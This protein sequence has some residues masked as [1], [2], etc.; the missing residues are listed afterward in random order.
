MSVSDLLSDREREILCLVATGASNKEIAQQL[1]ISTNTVKV[2]LR[3]IFDK[4][5][6]TSRT[7]AAMVAVAE[8]M[9]AGFPKAD[10]SRESTLGSLAVPLETD[11]HLDIVGESVIKRGITRWQ[12]SIVILGLVIIG[13]GIIIIWRLSQKPTAELPGASSAA[14]KVL[15]P[16]QHARS[17]LAAAVI[18]NQIYA[19]AGRS[20]EG[21]TGVVE[22]YDPNS[23]SW[24]AREDKPVA[25][26]E[27]QGVVIGGKIYVP[28]GQLA[29][30][31]YTD[32]LEIYDP[33]RDEWSRGE[34]LPMQGSSY[35]LV[36][37]EGKMYL[38][39]GMN[40]GGVLDTILVYD[41]DS[42][43][44]AYKSSLPI[45]RAYPGVVEVGGAIYLLGG[46]DGRRALD[47]VEIYRPNL[48]D[49]DGSPWTTLDEM[50]DKRYGMGITSLLEVIYLLGGSESQENGM[51]MRGYLTRT[52]EW[53]T[54][55]KPDGDSWTG[56]GLVSVGNSIYAFGGK[57]G[58]TPIADLQSMQVVYISVL[59]YIP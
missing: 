14:W 53:L 31:E 39:G 43:H 4:I 48:D 44:W 54:I 16:M 23:N 42:N 19:L 7:E 25:V 20:V 56:M 8:G 49:G 33:I 1:F 50:P 21:V 13:I 29:S 17:G 18:N 27:V 6:V 38:F 22:C 10:D 57:R 40:S 5:G 12:I 3:N 11:E 35:G 41:P 51:P 32:I 34:S 24:S 58:D 15:A 30:G 37:F 26:T 36:G 46:Y 9:V 45:P 47:S 2:H 59:P 55:L 52:G 28:G